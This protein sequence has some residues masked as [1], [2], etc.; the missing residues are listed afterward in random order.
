MIETW[1]KELFGLPT[2]QFAG[3]VSPAVARSA[4]SGKV[5]QRRRFMV[6]I[7]TFSA[8]FTMDDSVFPYFQSFLYYKLKRGTAW[9]EMPAVVNGVAGTYRF[10]IV[11][12]KYQAACSD[13]RWSVSTTI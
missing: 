10:R 6:L 8:R 9:F 3:T 4:E 1:P 5:R 11:E 12:G 13:N 2:L 7:Y